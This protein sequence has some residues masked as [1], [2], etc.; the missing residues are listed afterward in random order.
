MNRRN[1]LTALLGGIASLAHTPVKAACGLATEPKRV[2]G[3][4][5]LRGPD[6]LRVADAAV[7]SKLGF[8]YPSREQFIRAYR[9]HGFDRPSLS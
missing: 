5:G 8:L 1:W 3:F 6:L 2:V 4:I 9:I 7:A